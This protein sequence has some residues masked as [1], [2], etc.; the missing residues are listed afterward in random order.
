MTTE[1]PPTA[2]VTGA[3]RGIGLAIARSLAASHHLLLVGR[4]AARLEAAARE[5]DQGLGVEV[6][7]T[8]LSDRASTLAL[9][10]RVATRDV[11]VLVNNAGLAHSAPLHRTSDEDWDRILAV[12]LWAPFALVRCLAPA[13]AKRGF[14][15]VISVASTAALKGYAYTAAY[16]AAKAGLVGMTRGLSREYSGKG[17]T[18]NTVCPGFVDTDIVRDAIA[19]ITTKTGRSE[20]EARASIAGFNP[21]GRLLTPEEVAALVAWLASPAAAS[22]TGQAWAID[23]GETT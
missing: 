8:D 4:D 20:T 17:V 10:E 6:L 9:C 7:P 13:M 3:G 2:L 18:F 19:T 22:V 16:S 14:G 11:D 12:D 15:R 5:V 1:T 21:Q 23:G